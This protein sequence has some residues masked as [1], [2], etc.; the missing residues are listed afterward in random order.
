[1]RVGGPMVRGRKKVLSAAAIF[2]GL[3]L[4][5]WG[6]WL[7][8][9]SNWAW[10]ANAASGADLKT[11][12]SPAVAQAGMFFFIVGLL[13]AAIFVEDIDIFVRLFLL[14]IAFV[15]LLLVLAGSTTIFG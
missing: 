15:A 3:F 12:W 1:M 7:G 9:A 10:N 2:P 4:L 5:A 11:A 14:I 13:G 8:A 6:A